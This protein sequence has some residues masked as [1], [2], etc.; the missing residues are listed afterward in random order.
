MHLTDV[1]FPSYQRKIL[2]YFRF[3]VFWLGDTLSCGDA[4]VTLQS[5]ILLTPK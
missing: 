2:Q 1:L 3:V 5:T 4:A